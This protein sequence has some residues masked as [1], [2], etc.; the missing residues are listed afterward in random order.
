M[1]T[2]QPVKQI[3]ASECSMINQFFEQ[4]FPTSSYI[5]LLKTYIINWPFQFFQEK[6]LH[7]TK[8]SSSDSDVF[9]CQLVL[10]DANDLPWFGN[11]CAA[12]AT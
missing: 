12:H 8:Q 2:G 5:W 3:V 9:K 6:L 10:K 7:C 11:V 4:V 1:K